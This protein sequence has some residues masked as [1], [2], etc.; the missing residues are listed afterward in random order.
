MT[1]KM[2]QQTHT[3]NK[4]R[5]APTPSGYLHLG[6]VLSFA[7]TAALAKQTGAKI[8]LRIDD[9]DRDRVN[10]LYVQD[11]FDTLNFLE[12]PYDEGPRDFV[13]YEHNWSQVHRME[14]YR[15]ALQQLKDNNQLFACECSRAQIR[16]ISAV[17]TYTG[18][19]RHKSIALNAENMS[20]R[21]KT[22][23]EELS[24]KT[25]SGEVIKAPLPATMHDF[26][27]RKKDGYPA[28]QPTSVLDDVF[29]GVDLI[30]RG[31]DLWDSTLAQNYLA[32]HIGADAF[33][34]IT[35]YHH[36]LLMASGNE[37]L[38]KSA[39]AT[40][41]H[42][43]RSEGKKPADVFTAAAQMMGFGVRVK[44]WEELAALV[45]IFEPSK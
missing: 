25:L 20:W 22:N 29:Y 14:I 3:F 38:S 31:Q 45:A 13:D 7:I 24:I 9:L 12:I 23:A 41:V 27:V 43:L 37:K 10:P 39:G 42:Y 35:F 40:S 2:I 28:Y 18:T 34:D 21:L 44:D 4:T 11:I 5:I 17:D 1:R 15:A 26:V 36:P 16:A 33:R 19:C 30:V 32:P 6:N 8:L